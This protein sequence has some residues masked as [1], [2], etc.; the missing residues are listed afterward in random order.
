MFACPDCKKLE[1]RIDAIEAFLT[2]NINKGILYDS[3]A[4]DKYKAPTTE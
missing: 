1:Q 3:M 2:E 4:P